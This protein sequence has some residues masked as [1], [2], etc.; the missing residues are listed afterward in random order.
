MRAA[1]AGEFWQVPRRLRDPLLGAAGLLML[2]LVAAFARHAGP[3]RR[4][5]P[6]MALHLATVMPAVPLGAIVL[7][8]GK[9]GAAHR[10]LGRI[11]V[12]LMLVGA[13]ASFGVREL[14]GTLGPIHL[15]SIVTLVSLPRSIWA[16]RRG[17]IAAHRRGMLIV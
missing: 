1:T 6:W 16:A 17:R 2:L 14:M 7:F 5:S 12:A 3:P 4:I 11:W 13:V 9:G 8:R 10:L 15:L